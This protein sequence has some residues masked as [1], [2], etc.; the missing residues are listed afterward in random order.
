MR[1]TEM[2]ITNI[3]LTLT[4]DSEADAGYINTKSGDRSVSRTI[5][6]QDDND[7]LYGTID[8]AADGTLLGIEILGVNKLLPST[9]T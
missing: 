4:V 9:N 8:L 6:I 1:R 3:A 7:H 2:A 5:P